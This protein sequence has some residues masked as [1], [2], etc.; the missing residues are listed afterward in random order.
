MEETG[1][2]QICSQ[3]QNRNPIESHRVDPRENCRS[4]W[5]TSSK[6][7]RK[8]R[9]EIQQT[10]QHRRRSTRSNRKMVDKKLVATTVNSREIGMKRRQEELTTSSKKTQQ[11]TQK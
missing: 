6:I 9:I 1:I 5:T 8:W 10:P 11:K 4:G 3:Q 7:R 2:C